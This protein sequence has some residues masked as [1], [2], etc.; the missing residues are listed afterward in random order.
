MCKKLW[1][2]WKV[3]TCVECPQ[4]ITILSLTFRLLQVKFKAQ[5]DV[6]IRLVASV[7]NIFTIF[8][9]FTISLLCDQYLILDSTPSLSTTTS[10]RLSK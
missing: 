10:I 8:Q 6:P 4:L 9:L 7:H 2:S 1:D 3:T 5:S